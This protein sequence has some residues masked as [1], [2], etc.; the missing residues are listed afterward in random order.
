MNGVAEGTF[1]PYG[2]LSRAMI[3]TILYRQEGSPYA[4]GS[5]F[6]DV[7]S[8]QYYNAA[9]A[10]ASENGIV[11]GYI[12]GSFRPNDAVSMQE[13]LT[14]FYRYAQ[15]KSMK[16]D[17]YT[18]LNSYRDGSRVGSY[19]QTAFQWA[20]ANKLMIPLSTYLYPTEDADRG[21]AAIALKALNQL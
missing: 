6:R 9:V 5:G 4:S 21:E 18:N 8:N 19:A 16:T 7:P 12:D 15:K 13:M 20:L 1:K 2:S 10:W 11:N 3:V 14:I 17:G